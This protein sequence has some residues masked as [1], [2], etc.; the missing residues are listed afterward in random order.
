MKPTY[1]IYGIDV[2]VVNDIH[3]AFIYGKKYTAKD[4][5]TIACIINQIMKIGGR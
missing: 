3:T 5:G 1:T 2:W 4:R